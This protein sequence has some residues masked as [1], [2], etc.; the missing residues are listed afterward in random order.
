M[1]FAQD[2]GV[3]ANQSGIG[4]ASDG[5]AYT[6]TGNGT[7][8][9]VSNEIVLS[10]D[11]ADTSAQLGTRT[12][13]DAEVLCRIA[14]ANAADIVGIQARYSV[15]GGNV[16]SYKALFYDGGLHLN[17]AVSGESSQL[18]TSAFT[19]TPGIFYWFRLRVFGNALYG[20]AWQSGT[21][22]PGGWL[23]TTTDADVT[24]AGGFALLGNTANGSSVKFDHFTAMSLV[25]VVRPQHRPFAR[26][27]P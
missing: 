19:M 16:S 25:P 7:F 9:I 26:M 15:S 13:A 23:T 24:G 8:S 11:G 18:T 3:R 22:E 4:T 21:A 27:Q 12:L 17:K 5:Q 6:I 20:R 14:I 2:T 1:I 10:S